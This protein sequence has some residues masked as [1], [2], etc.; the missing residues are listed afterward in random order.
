MS[1]EELKAI[2]ERCDTLLAPMAELGAELRQHQR[3]SDTLAG[4]FPDHDENGGIVC[5]CGVR[6][7]R[8]GATAWHRHA[9]GV[10]ATAMAAETTPYEKF[11]ESARSDIPA[12]LDEVERLLHLLGIPV[13]NPDV[14][15]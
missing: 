5:R 4:H 12:L 9:A 1:P 2:R 3:A 11:F 7:G 13:V 10:M 6:F 14:T 15:P 8:V